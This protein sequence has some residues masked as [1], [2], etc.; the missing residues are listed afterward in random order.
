M[1]LPLPDPQLPG[2][3]QDAL[4]SI[5]RNFEALANNASS[6]PYFFKNLEGAWNAGNPTTST[7]GTSFTV[8]T[9]GDYLTIF[10]AGTYSTTAGALHTVTAHLN[11][12]STASVTVKHYQ[13]ASLEH[14]AFTPQMGI[15]SLRAGTN[16]LWIKQA[17][18]SVASDGNDFAVFAG[19]KVS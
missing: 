15:L 18:T 17:G 8:P 19:I 3:P 2:N 4:Q 11:G 1:A 9:S 16:Y 13:N 10:S 5:Q 14:H 12:S 7:S 6:I